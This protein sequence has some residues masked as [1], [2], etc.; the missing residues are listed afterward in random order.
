MSCFGPGTDLHRHLAQNAPTL[1]SLS[2]R[3][4]F[5]V[6]AGGAISALPRTIVSC[7]HRNA[8]VFAMDA[9]SAPKASAT[10]PSTLP[11]AQRWNPV[12]LP[13]LP[14]QTQGHSHLPLTSLVGDTGDRIGRKLKTF[15][16]VPKSANTAHR[17]LILGAYSRSLP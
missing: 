11:A 15:S 10:M 8:Q 4:I 6:H 7:F 5:F 17:P 14:S 13:Y 16:L 12:V 2:Y 1:C 9:S 3:T